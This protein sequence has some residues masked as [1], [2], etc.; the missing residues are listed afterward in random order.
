[1]VLLIVLKVF[2][3]AT[4]IQW[5]NG[6][7]QTE[8]LISFQLSAEF[9][10]KGTSLSRFMYAIFEYFFTVM[11]PRATLPPYFNIMCLFV[12]KI[13]YKNLMF[14]FQLHLFAMTR[15]FPSFSIESASSFENQI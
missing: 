11:L 6:L 12:C 5:M 8:L 10:Y 13:K 2:R 4:T 14:S 7:I 1:M 9:C 3:M 15:T